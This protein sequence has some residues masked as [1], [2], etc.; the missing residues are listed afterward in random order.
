MDRESS[1]L[2]K[3][4]SEILP[5]LSKEKSEEIYALAYTLYENLRY[6]DAGH[7]F[8]L[9]VASNPS[10][11]KFWKG[12]GATMQMQKDYDEAL[13]C[14]CCCLQFSVQKQPD[15]YLYLQTADCHFALKQ[16]DEGLNTLDVAH[17][18]A[19]KIGDKRVLQHVALMQQVW[20]K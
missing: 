10:E 1:D 3:E 5:Q 11:P 20:K 14:Y 4:K 19:K 9:L 15:P 12:L 18:I 13:N 16:V 7:F 17:L 2:S 6:E 8:R